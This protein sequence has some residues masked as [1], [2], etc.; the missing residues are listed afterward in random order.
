[1]ADPHALV[2]AYARRLEAMGGRFATGDAMGLSR[3][4]EEWGVS[5]ADGVVEAESVVVALGAH[6]AR[7]TSR[8]GYSPRYSGNVDITCTMGFGGTRC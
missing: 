7:L 1:M 2:V 8:F 5:A 6:S 3:A 4:G